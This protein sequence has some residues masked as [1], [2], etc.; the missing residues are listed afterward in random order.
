MLIRS[1]HSCEVNRN[2]YCTTYDLRCA[3]L[4]LSSLYLSIYIKY[5]SCWSALTPYRRWRC[6]I[7]IA[8]RALKLRSTD[9]VEGLTEDCLQVQERAR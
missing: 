3:T 8:N 1:L 9:C 5:A 7:L 4:Q 6:G 2:F